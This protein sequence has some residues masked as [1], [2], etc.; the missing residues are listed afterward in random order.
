M[1]PFCD[2]HQQQTASLGPVHTNLAIFETP[3]FLHKSA[4][5]SQETSKSTIQEGILLKPRSR[6]R[7][8]TPSTRIRVKNIYNCAVTKIT[9]LV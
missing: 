1:K 4:I 8:E 5:R 7:F 9:R 6:D 2:L 3:F